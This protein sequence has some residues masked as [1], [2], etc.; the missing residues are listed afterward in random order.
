VKVPSAAL[1]AEGEEVEHVAV[2]H[3][4]VR[5]HGLYVAL[6]HGEAFV[7]CGRHGCGGGGAILY[8]QRR[9]CEATVGG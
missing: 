5:A 2:F 7:W 8:G 4:A 6:H 3:L 9:G 1:A